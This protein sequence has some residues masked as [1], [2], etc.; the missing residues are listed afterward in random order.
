MRYKKLQ[1]L[2]AKEM[3]AKCG[4]RKQRSEEDG[5]TTTKEEVSKLLEQVVAR[6]SKKFALDGKDIKIIYSN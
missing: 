5:S 3:V 4:N 1:K 2:L 6:E